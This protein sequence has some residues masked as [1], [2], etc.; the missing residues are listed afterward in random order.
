VVRV[1]SPP[2]PELEALEEDRLDLAVQIS[3]LLDKGVD[4]VTVSELRKRLFELEKQI[5]RSR[6]RRT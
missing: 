5:A 6:K 4:F 1:I 3:L 2:N